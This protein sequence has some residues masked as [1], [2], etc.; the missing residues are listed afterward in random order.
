MDTNKY[1]QQVCADPNRRHRAIIR[2]NEHF[3]GWA[4]SGWLQEGLI[5]HSLKLY[6]PRFS[7]LGYYWSPDREGVEKDQKVPTANVFSSKGRF[8]KDILFRLVCSV[9]LMQVTMS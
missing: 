9:S 2:S 4:V 6:Y 8:H 5:N 3:E 1:Q 7:R